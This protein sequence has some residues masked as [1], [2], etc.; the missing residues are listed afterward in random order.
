[1]KLK[2]DNYIND[3][4]DKI[5]T[6][7][8]EKKSRKHK[9]SGKLSAGMLGSPLQWQ[10]LKHLNVEQ[11]P[12]DAY[13]LR[14][15]K[16]GVDIEAWL[17]KHIPGLIDDQKF[18]EYRQTVGYIDA[19]VDTESYNY[20]VGIIPHEIKSVT[21]A[22]Y[23]WITSRGVPDDGHILQAGLYALAIGSDHFAIDYIASD[24]LRLTSFLLE[25]KDYKERIDNIIDEYQEQLKKKEIPVFVPLQKWQANKIYN[26]YPSWSDLNQEEIKEKAKRLGI[27][28]P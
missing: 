17:Q 28:F 26:N 3:H 10:I 12:I 4:I 11:R 13:T 25:T 7:A 22:K 27:T 1:M 21:N 6:E 23:K 9:S 20:P 24:D 18:V 14:K 15:F 19:L 16:R 5:L 2:T 8:N